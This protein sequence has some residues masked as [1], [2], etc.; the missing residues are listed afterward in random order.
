VPVSVTTSPG[1]LLDRWS[2]PE[3]FDAYARWTLY[4]L[5]ATEPVFVLW[6]IAPVGLG[7]SVGVLLAVVTVAHTAACVVAMRAG[8]R[9]YLGG[10]G[11]AAWQV[12]GPAVLAVALVLA[13]LAGWDQAWRT[14]AVGEV[15]RWVALVLVVGVMTLGALSALLSVGS[16]VSATVLIAAGAVAVRAALGDDGMSARTVTVAAA[17]TISATAVLV[18]YRATVWM[19]GI[20]WEL[21]R[22]RVAHARL[23]VAEERLR[24]S[25]DLHDVVGRALA[26]VAVKSELAAELSTRGRD[27]AAAQMLEVREVAHDTLREVR[28]VV[29]GYRETDLAAELAGARSV[30]RSAGVDTRVMGEDVAAD[31]PEPVAVALAWVVREGVTNVVRHAEAA[32]C[33]L[34][35]SR[36]AGGDV[37]LRLV[38]DGV[39]PRGRTARRGSGL[40]GLAE[41]LAPLGGKV[42]AGA[43]GGSFVLEA[44]VAV[45]GRSGVTT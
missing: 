41:R 14:P 42:T 2:E 40:V 28:A 33:T 27:G 24:F 3:K 44:R 6:V 34:S 23:A 31:L 5:C 7:G 20:V 45:P 16:L 10:A 1:R 25:R 17:F 29:E 4:L 12:A 43:D 8:L 38:N 32:T 11:V 13:A 9:H 15:D 19:V 35:L 21:E 22:S 30:L 37:L 26:A 36:E 18:S 39:R